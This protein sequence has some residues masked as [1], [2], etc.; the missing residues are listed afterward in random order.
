MIRNDL[1]YA[2]T[3]GRPMLI[4]PLKAQAFLDN[5]NIILSNPDIAYHMSAWTDKYIN[6]SEKKSR[7]SRAASPWGDDEDGPSGN[8]LE[9]FFHELLEPKVEDNIGY[10]DV[11]GVIG[12]G[13]TKVERMLG[14]TDLC[15]IACTLDDWEKRDDVK[16]VVFR[17]DSGG[18]STTGLEEIAK[19]IRNYPKATTAYCE[20]DCGSA[21][22]WLASQC[23]RFM[24]TPSSNIGAVGIYLTLKD[25]SEKYEK[26]GVKIT[27]IKSGDYK[28]AGVEHMPLTALQFQRLQDEVVELH[29]RFIRD[30]MSVRAFVDEENLQGQSFYGDESVKIGMATSLVDEWKQ[31]KAI[32]K[33]NRAMAVSPVTSKLMARNGM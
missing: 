12:K 4:D 32:I 24:V 10:I 28:A 8:E 5:A 6:K 9:N 16:D 33:A 21:A 23:D 17:F 25:L 7:R 2:I 22:Y 30:V 14:C 27:V 20:G 19:K 3:A 29:R 1:C 11:K 15:D 31:A 13:L 26:D 18:G